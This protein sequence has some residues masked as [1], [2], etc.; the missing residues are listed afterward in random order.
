MRVE[1]G[2]LISLQ[3]QQQQQQQHRRPCTI[4]LI[5]LPPP[6]ERGAA[7]LLFAGACR[8]PVLTTGYPTGCHR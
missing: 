5:A 3:Q 1:D 4:R 7:L 2:T 6:Y 8:Y